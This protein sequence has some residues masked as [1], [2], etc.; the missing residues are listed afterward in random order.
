MADMV[1]NDDDGD[2]DDDYEILQHVSYSRTWRECRACRVRAGGRDDLQG[3]REG[4][5][6]CRRPSTQL[7]AYSK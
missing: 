3:R 6:V 4:I 5:K 2:D 1:D 7:T